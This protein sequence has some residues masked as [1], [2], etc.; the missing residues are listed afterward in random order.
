MIGVD[1]NDVVVQKHWS[2]QVCRRKTDDSIFERLTP[3]CVLQSAYFLYFVN[4]LVIH[5]SLFSY[6][7]GTAVHI[8]LQMPYLFTTVVMEML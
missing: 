5:S 6:W 7:L 2:M 8:P 3:V 1:I 4:S